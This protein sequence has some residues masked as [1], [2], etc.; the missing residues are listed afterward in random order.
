M[1][2][3]RAT[4]GA[5]A[6]SN[7]QLHKKKERNSFMQRC[8]I[9]CCCCAASSSC[10]TSFSTKR[11]CQRWRRRRRRVDDISFVRSPAQRRRRLLGISSSSLLLLLMI[12]FWRQ[13]DSIRR[14][15]YSILLFS[16]LLYPTRPMCANAIAIWRY[17]RQA[18]APFFLFL[19]KPKVIL[20]FFFK[21]LNKCT[22]IIIQ[23]KCKFL[24]LPL[25]F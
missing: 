11:K 1:R 19:S 18:T 10:K 15:L 4:I 14:L 9:S 23:F 25:L 13:F 21:C 2:N 5:G 16:T 20:L 24:L 22:G 6:K 7:W 12:S 8:P 17:S 3:Y